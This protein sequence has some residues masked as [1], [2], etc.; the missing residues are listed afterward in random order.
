MNSVMYLRRGFDS[1]I[2][3]CSIL[4]GYLRGSDGGLLVAQGTLHEHV[5]S[6]V[7][8]SCEQFI[9]DIPKQKILSFGTLIRPPTIYHA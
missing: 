5:S 4:S 7:T 2:T 9:E 6:V 3:R 8:A 1:G